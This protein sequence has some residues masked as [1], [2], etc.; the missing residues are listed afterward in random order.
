MNYSS[1]F[2]VFLAVIAALAIWSISKHHIAKLNAPP[3]LHPARPPFAFVSPAKALQMDMGQ[4]L[5]DVERRLN[6]QWKGS[7]FP[8]RFDIGRHPSWAGQRTM[9]EFICAL[10]EEQGWVVSKNDDC[11]ET[12]I[13]LDLPRKAFEKVST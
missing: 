12:E 13:I 3:I 2:T 11:G 9:M 8:M 6:R 10:L 7:A 4:A 5:Y 1:F